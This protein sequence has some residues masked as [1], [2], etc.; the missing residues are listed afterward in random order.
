MSGDISTMRRYCPSDS[1][2]MSGEM[3]DGRSGCSVMATRDQGERVSESMT[4]PDFIC[5][6]QLG[7]PGKRKVIRA[8]ASHRDA[9]CSL[10]AITG[11][12]WIKLK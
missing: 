4:D 8:G 6:Y 7:R 11:Y 2:D 9:F 3:D 5:Y 10:S 12:S 1:R